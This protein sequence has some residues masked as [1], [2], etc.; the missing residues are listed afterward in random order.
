[1]SL[2]LVAS[3]GMA[4]MLVTLIWIRLI[5]ALIPCKVCKEDVAF[6][7]LIRVEVGAG[8]TGR[9]KLSPHSR[10]KNHCHQHH[11]H[12]ISGGK[13]VEG[14]FL[15]NVNKSLEQTYERTPAE[16]ISH[17]NELEKG[18]YSLSLMAVAV[19]FCSCWQVEQGCVIVLEVALKLISSDQIWTSLPN[20]GAEQMQ[21]LSIWVSGGFW[22]DKSSW[23]YRQIWLFQK[24]SKKPYG[25]IPG[26]LD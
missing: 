20:L 21:F 25:S 4:V 10:S 16:R 19:M 12:H 13:G 15:L 11:H 24:I 17:H 7:V 6:R 3:T 5:W 26:W 8:N 23:L 18:T 2:N 14:N 22:R 9:K 1:V